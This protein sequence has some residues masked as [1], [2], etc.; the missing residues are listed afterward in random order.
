MKRKPNLSLVSV[1]I[2]PETLADRLARR[3]Y[4]AVYRPGQVNACPGCGRS[5]WIVG[6]TSAECAYAS[7]GALLPLSPDGSGE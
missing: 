5:Q 1:L 2:K 4:K 7:C 3:A 6:R